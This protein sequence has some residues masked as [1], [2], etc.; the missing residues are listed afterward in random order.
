MSHEEE[1]N[2]NEYHQNE[3]YQHDEYQHQEEEYYQPVPREEEKKGSLLWLVILLG[4]LVV[5]EGGVIGYLFSER[6]DLEAKATLAEKKAEEKGAESESKTKELDDLKS[7]FEAIQAENERMGIE[8]NDLKADIE[9]LN[10]MIA[11]AQSGGLSEAQI[12]KKYDGQLK[13]L[14]KELAKQS[15]LIANLKQENA[16]LNGDIQ[17]IS[18]ERTKMSDSLG[19]VSNS[20]AEM[21]KLIQAASVLKAENFQFST[22][23]AKGKA[24]DGTE[25]SPKNMAKLRVSFNFADNK[26][27][28]KGKKAV[29]FAIIDPTN[30]VFSDLDMGGG[31]TDVDGDTKSYTAEMNVDFNNTQQRVALIYEKD[32]E[33]TKGRYKVEVYCEGVK[34]GQSNFLVK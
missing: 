24:F 13:K 5:A 23:T 25:F 34:I 27:A 29:Y 11:E 8:N 9:R 21:E 33:Y 7:Q 31:T 3:E 17:T 12:K 2:N 14:K 10:T 1:Y 6:S 18:A 4:V 19:A 26:V 30:H 15:Q 22:L 32:G 16:K 20:K 28:K